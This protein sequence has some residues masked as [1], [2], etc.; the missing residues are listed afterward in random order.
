MSLSVRESLSSQDIDGEL[1]ILDKD[2]GQIHQL[3]SV[4]SA[5]TI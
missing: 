3:N 4:A 2:N 1:V 5:I